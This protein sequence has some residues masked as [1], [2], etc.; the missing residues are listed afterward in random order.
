MGREKSYDWPGL[1]SGV[2][3]SFLFFPPFFWTLFCGEGDCRIDCWFLLLLF[4]LFPSD[5]S[6]EVL[7]RLLPPVSTLVVTRGREP[8][9]LR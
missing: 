2:L 7:R 1:C 9:V 3:I 5:L 6:V 4:C 8:Q